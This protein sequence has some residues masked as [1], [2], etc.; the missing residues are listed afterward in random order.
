MLIYYQKW[1]LYET[2]VKCF[3]NRPVSLVLDFSPVYSLFTTELKIHLLGSI[4]IHSIQSMICA[5]KGFSRKPHVMFDTQPRCKTFTAQPHSSFQIHRYDLLFFWI[6]APTRLCSFSSALEKVPIAVSVC[7]RRCSPVMCWS[8][9]H[10]HSFTRKK[11][12]VWELSI[13]ENRF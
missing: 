6:S 12:N 9:A 3:N 10:I 1:K 8:T 7:C 2:E 5:L 13:T 4:M 11:K